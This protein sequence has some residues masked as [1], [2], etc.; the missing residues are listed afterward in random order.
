MAEPIFILHGWFRSSSTAAGREVIE[1]LTGRAGPVARGLALAGGRADSG[2]LNGK[3]LEFLEGRKL[4]YVVVDRLT[5]RLKRAAAGAC[6]WHQI[7]PHIKAGE[8]TESM[9]SWSF[10]RVRKSRAA[11]GR[12]LI[13]V[14]GYAYRVFGLNS[15]EAPEAIGRD[16]NQR[17]ALEQCIDELESDLRADDFCRREF[18]TTEAAF[19]SVLLLLNMLL[20]WHTAARPNQP[21]RRPATLGTEVF[22]CGAIAGTNGRPSVLNLSRA[23][24]GFEQRSPV[25][26]NASRFGRAIPPRLPETVSSSSSAA[27]PF[28]FLPT[29]PRSIRRA[30]ITVCFLPLQLSFPSGS[31]PCLKVVAMIF[32]G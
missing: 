8:F 28:S 26:P 20:L 2:F 7:D 23:W 19:R 14:P 31:H 3:L 27:F 12:R 21:Y 4:F 5:S 32:V 11:T 15:A 29:N 9:A 30:G 10:E 6:L 18:Y 22:L 16:Y 13:K 24:G 1:F 17:A 25:I